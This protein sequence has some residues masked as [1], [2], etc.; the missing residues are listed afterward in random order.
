MWTVHARFRI[1]SYQLSEID[2]TP[3]IG[4]SL[5][6]TVFALIVRTGL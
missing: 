6:V 1:G 2:I 3:V 4:I 5:I